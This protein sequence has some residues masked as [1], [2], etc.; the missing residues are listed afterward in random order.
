MPPTITDRLLPGDHSIAPGRRPTAVCMH[1]TDG[2][3]VNGAISHWN[4][5]VDASAHY[6]VDKDG[7]ITRTVR[8]EHIAWSNGVVRSPDMGNPLIAHWVNNGINPN[9]MTI[10]IEI[11][12]R[13][14]QPIQTAQW[15]SV[16]WLVADICLRWAIPPDRD[17][18]IGHY[19]IDSI[20]RARCPSLSGAQWAALV[21]GAGKRFTADDEDALLER[22]YQAE[23][24]RLKEK[25]HKSWIARPYYSGVVLFTGEGVVA[26]TAALTAIVRRGL[27]DD[28]I[29]VL[30]SWGQSG[31]IGAPAGG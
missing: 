13:P 26:P 25:R 3:T 16:V 8:E 11:V 15:A 30:E 7:S 21:E 24:T 27:M 2:D 29:S 1:I 6:L 14:G 18:I 22:Q 10:G 23:I 9:S 31:R 4:G 17:H 5:P 28:M 19:Q 12:G 20:S